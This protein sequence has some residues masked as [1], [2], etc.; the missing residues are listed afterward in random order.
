MNKIYNERKLYHVKL[1]IFFESNFKN[2]K[3]IISN[4]NLMK[5]CK[6]CNSVTVTV[7]YTPLYTRM[8]HQLPTFI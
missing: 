2:I 4:K 1:K 5:F 7:K 3:K 8:Y 6:S